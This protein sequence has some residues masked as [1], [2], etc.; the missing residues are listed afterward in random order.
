MLSLIQIAETNPYIIGAPQSQSERMKRQT[1]TANYSNIRIFPFLT[2]IDPE[3]APLL[4][5]SNSR[6]SRSIEILESILMVNP[7]EGNF[8]LPPI[9]NEYNSGINEGRCEDP[10]PLNVTYNCGEFGVVP[11]EYIGVRAVCPANESCYLDGPNGTGISDTDYLLFV[12]AVN[13][14][15]FICYSNIK[16]M[17]SFPNYAYFCLVALRDEQV[18]LFENFVFA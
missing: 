1:F 18:T 5:Q 9:C 15:E 16:I 12:S 2:N 7:L 11:D 10:L 13:T 8:I 6:L 3:I 4:N 14:C 17:C